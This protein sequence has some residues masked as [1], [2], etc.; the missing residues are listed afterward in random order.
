MSKP[1]K[2]KVLHTRVPAVLE[3]ELKRLATSLRVPVS[4]VVR[5]ILQDAVETV[6]V[7]QERAEDELRG[8]ADRLKARRRTRKATEEADKAQAAEEVEAPAPPRAPL[9]GVLGYQPL[10]L[11]R[12]ERCI[13]CGVSIGAG[14]RA[15][16]GVREGAG[17]KVILDEGCLPFSAAG[18]AQHEEAKDDVEP[19]S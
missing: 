11:A 2:E 14:E 17:P 19:E 8:V 15:F 9:A 13:L 18:A 7:V 1:R 10:L 3:E 16:L 12:E 4:N 5:T 6:D